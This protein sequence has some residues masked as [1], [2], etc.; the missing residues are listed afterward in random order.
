MKTTK[1]SARDFDIDSSRSMRTRVLL[2]EYHAQHGTR[3][4]VC[5]CVCVIIN[6]FIG[7]KSVK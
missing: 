1:K 6:V 3:E 4:C 2:F 7:D 5:V